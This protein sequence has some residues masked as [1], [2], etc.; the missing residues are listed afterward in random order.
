MP[1]FDLDPSNPPK[2]CPQCAWNGLKSKVKKLKVEA[3]S[4][5]VVIMCK[6]E[7]VNY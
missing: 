5:D 3:G 7:K 4:N 2:Y 1:D 6:N